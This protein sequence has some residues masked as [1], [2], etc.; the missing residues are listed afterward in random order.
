MAPTRSQLKATAQALC[1]AFANKADTAT[2]LSHFSA[3]HQ[4]TALEH[5]LPLLAPFLGRSF[6]NLSGTNSVSTYFS[7]LP[8]YLT[9]EDMTFG[10]WVVD[11]E[12]RKV[13]VKGKAK[14]TWIEGKGEGQSW[15]E[16]FVVSSES[17]RAARQGEGI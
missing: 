16:Q 12:A 10:E 8:K 9:Y 6:T 13:C 4:A 2:I 5:G 11:E 3:T 1:S 7:L 17:R 14:F 15:N